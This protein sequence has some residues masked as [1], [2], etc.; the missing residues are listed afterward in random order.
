[1]Q[2]L[3]SAMLDGELSEEETAQVQ[4]HVAVCDDCRAMYDAFTAV[5][6]AVAADAVAGCS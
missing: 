3:I 2:A 6:A 5:S 4:A 1:M